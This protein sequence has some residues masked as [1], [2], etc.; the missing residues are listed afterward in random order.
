MSDTRGAGNDP[1]M[2]DILASIRK[3]ISDDEARST[4]GG[5]RAG[6]TGMPP[7]RAS[8][9]PRAEARPAAPPPMRAAQPAAQDDVLLLTDIMEE[10]R[11]PAAV[12]RA[13]QQAP[14]PPAPTLRPA[15]LPP[16]PARIDPARATEMP[17]PSVIHSPPPPPARPVASEQSYPTMQPRPPAPQ[18][19][20]PIGS[21][22]S[23]V[24]SNVIGAASSAFDRLNQA[25]QESEPPPAASNPG[26]AMGAGGKTIEDMVKEMLRPML[27]DWLDRNLPPMVER[28]V[29]REIVRLTRR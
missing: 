18:G 2:D 7:P 20:S 11:Q 12:P 5:P 28:I 9:P 15:P 22:Q 16:A 17:Q 6:S 13:Q 19:V 10:S 27:K 26:P 1:S 25:V 21:D 24:G 4:V 3:I 8:A 14:F 29:E 23:L